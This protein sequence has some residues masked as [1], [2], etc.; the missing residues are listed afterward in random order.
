VDQ[1]IQR[2]LDVIKESVLKTVPAE[3][4]YLFG[5]YA[6][7]EPNDDSDIDIYVVVPDNVGDLIDIRAEIRMNLRKKR[8]RDLDLLM[9]RSSVFNQRKKGPTLERVIA[10]DGVQLYGYVVRL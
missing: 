7:G 3:A 6:Y 10:R 5:S 9:G 1:N 2:E 8:S 4:I